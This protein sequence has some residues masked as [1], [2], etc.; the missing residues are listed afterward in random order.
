MIEKANV[1]GEWI[2]YQVRNDERGK[3]PFD[4][5]RANG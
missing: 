2:P 1:G 5:L 3:S 4:K